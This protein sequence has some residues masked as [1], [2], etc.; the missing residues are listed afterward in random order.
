MSKGVC[1]CILIFTAI[2]DVAM[3]A[4]SCGV[5]HYLMSGTCYSCQGST[6]MNS[7]SHTYSSCF[8]CPSGTNT[9]MDRAQAISQCI[10]MAGYSGNSNGATCAACP[11]RTYKS[12]RGT[13]T[14]TGCPAGTK[15]PW[16]GQGECRDCPAD[17]TTASLVGTCLPCPV[18]KFGPDT[19]ASV[20]SGQCHTTSSAQEC[21][22]CE[23]GLY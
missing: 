7:A 9:F 21:S 15:N 11:T 6:Y 1:L 23:F 13:G 12:G 10:C 20:C 3:C 14:C 22:Q 5:G 18:S 4:T 19:G 17:D 16:T 2:A 8:N